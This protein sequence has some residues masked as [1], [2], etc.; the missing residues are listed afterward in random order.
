MPPEQRASTVSPVSALPP[1][2]HIHTTHTHTLH[3]ELLVR[4]NK[5]GV[6]ITWNADPEVEG[7]SP[8]RFP[9]PTPRRHDHGCAA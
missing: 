6:C 3:R 7:H 2:L 5:R 8:G 9:G 4:T 1:P